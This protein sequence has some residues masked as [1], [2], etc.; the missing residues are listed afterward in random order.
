MEPLILDSPFRSIA[1][2]RAALAEPRRPRLPAL[3]ALGCA[4]LMTAAA[5]AAAAVLL[6]GGWT[7]AGPLSGEVRAAL[8]ER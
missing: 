6:L 3:A 7:P 8:A 4:G 1:A 2:A 5:F